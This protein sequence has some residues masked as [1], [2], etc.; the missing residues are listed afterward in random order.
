MGY[1]YKHHDECTYFDCVF[2]SFFSERESDLIS[3]VIVVE[4]NNIDLSKWRTVDHLLKFNRGRIIG[5]GGYTSVHEGIF[6][7]EKV[8]VKRVQLMGNWNRDD[9]YESEILARLNHPNVV[10][11]KHCA[12][13]EDFR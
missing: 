7:N 13:D 4:S 5:K 12:I 11:Y 10:Q 2:I 6:K 9:E 3:P 1:Y 8:A